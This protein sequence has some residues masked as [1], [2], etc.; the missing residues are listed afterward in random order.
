MNKL[1]LGG[2]NKR[3]WR[4]KEREGGGGRGDSHAS[5]TTSRKLTRN[6]RKVGLFK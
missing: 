5:V 3:G 2:K 4:I 6:L 1:F